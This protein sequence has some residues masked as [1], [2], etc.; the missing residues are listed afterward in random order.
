MV[1]FPPR[2]VIDEESLRLLHGR[3]VRFLKPLG[4]GFDNFAIVTANLDVHTSFIDIEVCELTDLKRLEPEE[5][6][7]EG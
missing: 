4:S 5:W 3:L 6:R 1:D 7:E 2:M